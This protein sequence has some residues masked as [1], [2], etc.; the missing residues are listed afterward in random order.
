MRAPL[1]TESFDTG[2]VLELVQLALAEAERQGASAAEA[3]VSNSKG[4]SV[5][6][7]QGEIDVLEHHRDQGFALTVYNGQRR[8]SA[9]TTDLSD[10]SVRAAVAAACSIARF[11]A[12]DEYAGLADPAD[13]ATEIPDL[14]LYHPW[15][16]SA[17]QAIELARSCE[18]EG[19]AVDK[20]II[21]S[22]GATVNTLEG[23]SIYGNTHG[24]IGGYAGS[25]HML[26]C[27]MIAGQG[28]EM[29]NDYWYTRARQSTALESAA[30]VGRKAAERAVQRLGARKLTT[31]QVPVLYAPDMATS[32]W[33]HF[34]EAI[35]GSVLYRQASFLLDHQGKQIFPAHIN[36]QE[37]PHLPAG[38]ASAPFD[39]E[40]VATRAHAIVRDGV[41]LEYVLDSYSARKLGLRTTGNAGGVR[42]LQV[43][44]DKM[45]G[46][47]ALLRQMDTGLLVTRMMGR[48]NN[49]VTGDYSRGAGGFWVENG[50]IQYPVEEITVA[51]NLQEMFRNIAGLGDDIDRRGG[52]LSG[53][54]LI[55]SMTVGG[56]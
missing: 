32:L 41:L 34:L 10:A 49:T 9:S 1:K 51:G 33:S 28:D 19:Y 21:N 17:Q 50:A 7:R 44:S 53:S 15:N 29:Q 37:Q 2:R 35:Q 22:E 8:G 48:G 14:D 23:V 43:Q 55:E 30:A 13:L 45:I 54:V 56:E 5:T 11:T 18:A 42:N 12:E 46:F 16:I 27:A 39:D 26:S 6:V 31:R 36:L 38:P 47:A 40:G 25:R 24:F 4:L 20:R 3:A 52:I